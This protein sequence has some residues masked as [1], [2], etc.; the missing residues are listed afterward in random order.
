M[1]G[2][3]SVSAMMRKRLSRW[4]LAPLTISQTK[5]DAVDA[6]P[7]LPQTKMRRPSSRAWMKM[8]MAVPTLSSSMVSI[9]F[10]TS[11]LYSSGKLAAMTLIKAQAPRCCQPAL[12][13][14]DDSRDQSRMCFRPRLSGRYPGSRLSVLHGSASFRHAMARNRRLIWWASSSV[15]SPATSRSATDAKFGG[16]HASSQASY[17]RDCR[18]RAPRFTRPGGAAIPWAGGLIAPA[19]A[20]QSAGAEMDPAGGLV[21]CRSDRFADPLLAVDGRRGSDV[22]VRAELRSRPRDEGHFLHLWPS[23]IPHF[24]AS[25]REQSGPGAGFPGVF[26]AI[27]CLGDGVSVFSRQSAAAKPVA[28]QL[29]LRTLDAALL[30][31]P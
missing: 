29:F 13:H 17:G 18:F 10:K 9:A 24:S 3:E 19:H 22:G 12:G 21:F 5:C 31:Y 4:K 23:G 25:F 16:V 11:A 15:A 14:H 8:S 2:R 27:S 6:L 30:V 20:R 7:P 26:V 1:V 28:L